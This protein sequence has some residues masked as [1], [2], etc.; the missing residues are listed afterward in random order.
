[1]LKTIS[2]ILSIIFLTA[3]SANYRYHGF[4]PSEE[5]LKEVVVGVDT[6]ETVSEI[7]GQPS[8][9][10]VLD[11]GGWY[12]V[13]SK[14]RHYAYQ[15]PKAVERQLVAISFDKEDVVQNIERFGLEDGRVITLS[16]R[17][18]DLPVKGPGIIEQL[19]G[20]LG[21]FDLTQITGQQN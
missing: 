9:S 10:G 4:A 15:A 14:F 1:M 6:R 13:S 8:S 7:I 5:E 20:N 2:V 19:L 17:V 3:C 18:T 16:R 21:N 11:D 12:Y